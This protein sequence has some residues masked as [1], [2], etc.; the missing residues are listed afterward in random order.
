MDVWRYVCMSC[1]YASTYVYVVVH[2][3][4][5]R[6]LYTHTCTDMT[7]DELCTHLHSHTSRHTLTHAG[8]KRMGTNT[9]SRAFLV[10]QNKFSSVHTKAQA[11]YAKTACSYIF[12]RLPN[13]RFACSH[14]HNACACFAFPP[15][16]SM[17]ASTFANIH[18]SLL[19]RVPQQ[20]RLVYNSLPSYSCA[21]LT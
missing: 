12:I 7:L 10:Y 20:C 8:I 18:K 6:M 16:K 2:V 5:V 9:L 17:Y 14:V 13:H 19:V 11:N 4:C 3:V 15:S 21:I 1:M